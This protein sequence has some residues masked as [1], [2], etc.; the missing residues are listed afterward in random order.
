M[1]CILAVRSTAPVDV[2]SVKPSPDSGTNRINIHLGHLD[3]GVVTLANITLS[4]CI[5][6]AY[7]LTSEDQVNAPDWIRDGAGA[8]TLRQRP[9]LITPLDQVHLMMQ[10]L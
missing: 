5:Q 7:G 10:A 9:Q 6:Y 3:H 1:R 2:A 8:S 4:E